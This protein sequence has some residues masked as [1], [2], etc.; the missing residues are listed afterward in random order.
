MSFQMTADIFDAGWFHLV[1]SSE[2][3]PETGIKINIDGTKYFEAQSTF[4][5][6]DRTASKDAS[7]SKLVLSS[8][9]VDEENPD[10]STY[11]EYELTPT[12]EKDT[13]N[14]ELNLLEYIDTMDMKVTLS[15]SNASMKMKVPKKDENNNL[16]YEED[17][18]TI[19]YEE[20]EIQNDILSQITLNK[21]G[22]PDTIVT[23]KVVAQD[24]ATTKDYTITIKR[25][26]GTIIGSIRYDEIEDNENPDVDKTT[27][28]NIYSTGKFNWEELQDIFGVNFENPATYDDLDLVEK[29]V[30]KQSKS[31]GTYEIYVI[32][33]TYDLQIDRRGFLDYI[34]TNITIN[35]KDVI[36]LGEIVIYAGDVNRDGVIGLED[37]RE[38]IENLDITEDS[39]DYDDKYDFV[40]YGSIGLESVRYCVANRD[41]LLEVRKFVEN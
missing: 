3:S 8:G 31:D 32:P 28:L 6:T 24:G 18:T 21:L 22:E 35:D 30:A 11:K 4:R 15:D 5:F 2:S 36:D 37:T 41:K 20:K 12:F 38:V 13:L 25:P 14:Y 16:M 10:N 26:Y 39:P 1:E 19:I 40:Q 33:G 7:L 23:V 17:G 27:D 29:D 34:I 9:V